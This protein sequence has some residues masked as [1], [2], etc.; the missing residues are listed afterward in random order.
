VGRV[1]AARLIE[2]KHLKSDIGDH[3]AE[4]AADSLAAISS[5][6]DEL[7]IPVMS[8]ADH[9]LSCSMQAAFLIR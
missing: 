6:L 4:L 3:P 1:V 9:T 7:A 8:Y 5:Y 2:A